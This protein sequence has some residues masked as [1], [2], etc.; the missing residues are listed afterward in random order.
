MIEIGLNVDDCR[1][2]SQT[3]RSKSEAARARMLASRHAS[4][5]LARRQ[6]WQIH[7]GPP[8]GRTR[9]SLSRQP[10]AGSRPASQPASGPA[11]NPGCPSAFPPRERIRKL[12]RIWRHFRLRLRGHQRLLLRSARRTLLF[13]SLL[14]LRRQQQW[15]PQQQRRQQQQPRPLSSAGATA[16]AAAPSV[17][18]A[19][20]LWPH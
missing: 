6:I 1:P 15:R 3:F 7:L 10:A 12:S 16:A 17:R 5:P 20:P 13:D 9:R 4:A 2:A 11:R 14:L 18:P 8:S 19:S